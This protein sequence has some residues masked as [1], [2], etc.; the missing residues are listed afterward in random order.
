MIIRREETSLY[1]RCIEDVRA[2]VLSDVYVDY[3][4]GDRSEKLSLSLSLSPALVRYLLSCRRSLCCLFHFIQLLGVTA[5]C[6][7]ELGVDIGEL[8][9][10]LHLGFPGKLAFS[11]ILCHT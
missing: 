11:R 4:S 2:C 6:A 9:V 10:T 7:L 8:A 1:R 5:T 3:A